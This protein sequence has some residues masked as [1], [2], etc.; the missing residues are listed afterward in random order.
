VKTRFAPAAAAVTVAAGLLIGACSS[1][2]GNGSMNMT[3][4]SV[5][6]RNTTASIPADA[7]FNATDVAFAQGMIPHHA[8]AVVMADMALAQSTSP[9]VTELAT[10]I[11]AAQTPEIEQLTKWLQAWGQPVPDPNGSMDLSMSDMDGMMMSGIMS[12]ADMAR[13]GN[14]TGTDFDSMWLEMM[15]QHHE[16]AISMARDEVTGGKFVATKALAESIV[17]SQQAEIDTMTM[18][19]TQR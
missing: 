8:Q 17:T 13:L 15:V 5:A 3:T 11:K 4:T 14:A 9:A 7:E 2:S 12:D 16:G 10:Q 6:A 1:S 19:M 18:L